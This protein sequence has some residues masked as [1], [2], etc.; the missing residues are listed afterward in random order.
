MRFI[1]LRTYFL[2]I[3]LAFTFTPSS[4]PLSF[5]LLH[6]SLLSLCNTRVTIS[7]VTPVCAF[8]SSLVQLYSLPTNQLSAYSL[9][10]SAFIYF[11]IHFDISQAYLNNIEQRTTSR[12]SSLEQGASITFNQ[13]SRNCTGYLLTAGYSLK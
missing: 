1:N 9:T 12:A 8:I 4:K 13:F 10:L 3:A 7:H 6:A 2:I 5:S 11:Y